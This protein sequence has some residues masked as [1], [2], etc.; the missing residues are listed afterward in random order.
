MSRTALVTGVSRGLGLAVARRLLGEG[1][2]VCGTSR[3]E[4][5]EWRDLAASHGGRAEWR[6][7]DLALPA[8]IKRTLFSE[9]IPVGRPVHAFIDNAAVAYDDLVTN[10]RLETVERMFAVNV[11]TPMAITREVVRNMVFHDTRGS[12]V[13][14]SSISVHAGGKGLAMYAATKGALEAF[15]KNTAREWGERGIRSNCVVAGYMDTEM[16][17]TLTEEQREKVQRRA[18]LKSVTEVESVA[19]TIAFLLSDD[20]CS[21]TGQNIFVDAGFSS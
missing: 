21:I 20:A 19:G 7:C 2:T 16:S 18:A 15:S 14:V 1:W 8:E 4:S 5:A 10:L 12:L 6:A 13:H 3:T 9:W 17:S 11:L